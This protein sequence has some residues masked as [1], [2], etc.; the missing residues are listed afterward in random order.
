[1]DAAQFESICRASG[2]EILQKRFTSRGAIML[3]ERLRYEPKEY[4]HPYVETWWASERD[5]MDGASFVR[6][7][8]AAVR[9]G[10]ARTITREDRISD[11]LEMAD[12]WLTAMDRGTE[13]AKATKR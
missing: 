5:G 4:P 11:A 7:D 1:M 2:C 13:L 10:V 8:F 3:A 6:N 9:N 12:D